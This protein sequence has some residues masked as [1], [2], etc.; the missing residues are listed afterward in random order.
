MAFSRTL[1]QRLVVPALALSAL[2]VGQ[3]LFA[4]GGAAGEAT[5][6]QKCAVCHGPDGA[7]AT[8]MGRTFKLQD[9]RSPAVQNLT[10]AQ[11]IEIVTKGKGKM[12][13]YGTQLT[14]TQIK[15]VVAYLRELAKP[16][17]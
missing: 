15:G 9:L 5:F 4:Q 13:A 14:S 12:P 6:K 3:A 8:A 10:D 7:G 16:K 1:T 2:L 11:L 17:K